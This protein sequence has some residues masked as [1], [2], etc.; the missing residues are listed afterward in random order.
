M[1]NGH[2]DKAEQLALFRYQV[3]SEAA[4]PRLT[5]AER[6]R[7]A[8]ELAART[9]VGPDGAER[10]VSR[11]SI[12]RWLAAY[13]KHGLAGLAPVPRSDRGRPRSARQWLEEAAKLRR[14]VPARSAAQ[15]AD[16]IARA[17][18]VL[19]SER[20]VRGHL[21][22]LGL[23]RRALSAAPARAFGRFEASRPNEIWIGDV[24]HGPFVPCPRV[25]GSKRAKLF[26]L[27]DD[28]SRLLVHGRW[29]TEENTRAGQDVLRAAISRRGRPELLYVDNGAPY[30][31]H[32]LSRACA[33]LGIALVHSK[34]YAPGPGQAG[35]A[36]LLYTVFVHCRG[37]GPGHGQFRR[38]ERPVH[39]LGRAGGQRPGARRDQTSASGQV[40]GK[41]YAG[42]HVARRAVRGLPLVGHPPGD[43]DG[44]G[45]L[46][47]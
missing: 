44:D 42:Y 26:L 2:Q 15:I 6:G 7:L 29:V 8:R 25:P 32:Q 39:G 13:A 34:P 9:W 46:V 19:L 47:G 11:T 23:S 41:L 35:K 10:Q 4:S 21:H 17:H 43:Q 3:I 28:Y 20:T 5:P 18:G 24:L 38:A 33:V 40:L 22:R 12:D 37:R 31:N 36:Q 45:Q 27:V 30:A 1:A 16:I 14:A